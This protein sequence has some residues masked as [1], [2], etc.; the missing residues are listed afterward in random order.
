MSLMFFHELEVFSYACFEIRRERDLVQERDL[1]H[2]RALCFTSVISVTSVRCST[3]V[4][5]LANVI[6]SRA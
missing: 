3:L 5:L 6:C 4:G 2:E 1:F